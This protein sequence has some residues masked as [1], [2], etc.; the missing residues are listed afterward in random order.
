MELPTNYIQ[1]LRKTPKVKG[2]IVS[3]LV[4]EYVRYL[5]WTNDKKFFSDKAF[6]YSMATKITAS[7]SLLIVSLLGHHLIQQLESLS[8]N[9]M[10]CCKR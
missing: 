1:D 5:V 3:N 4:D 7:H 2:T 9:G 6:L 10:V 8:G